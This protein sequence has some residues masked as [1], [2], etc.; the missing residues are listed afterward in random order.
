[1]ADC[2]SPTLSRIHGISRM[3]GYFIIVSDKKRLRLHGLSI[4]GLLHAQSSKCAY[5]FSRSIG[6]GR[7]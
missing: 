1:M 6:V 3:N 4:N 2:M 5:A 7:F